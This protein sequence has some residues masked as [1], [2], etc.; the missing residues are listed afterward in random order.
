MSPLA[1]GL[2]W[3][4]SSK[5]ATAIWCKSSSCTLHV[6]LRGQRRR[7]WEKGGL[8]GTLRVSGQ[9]PP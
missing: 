7:M 8:T 9:L 4:S 5:K 1:R 6:T 3:P 2:S